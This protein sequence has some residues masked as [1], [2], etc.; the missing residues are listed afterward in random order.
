MRLSMSRV[1]VVAIAGL[2]LVGCGSQTASNEAGGGQ[3]RSSDDCPLTAEALTKATALNWEL[4][5][6]KEDHPLETAE[7]IKATVC[8]YTA[9]DAPQRGSDPLV[10]RADVVTG[11]DAAAVRKDFS[12]TCTEYG[13]KVRSSASPEGAVVCDRDGS[14]V[15]GVI[16]SD[17]RVV[18][19]YLGNA[20]KATAAK[21]TPAFDQILAAVN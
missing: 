9:A 8:L 18:S 7:S 1:L 19:V 4:R 6:K 5:E 16:G 2:C 10:M 17:D 20:D 3:D 14:V 15:E 21:L 12:D 13:G 11:A